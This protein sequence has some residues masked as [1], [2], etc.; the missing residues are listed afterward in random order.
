[1]SPWLF[2]GGAGPPVPS[3][4]LDILRLCDHSFRNIGISCFH[5]V[6]VVPHLLPFPWACVAHWGGL[7]VDCSEVVRLWC[8]WGAVVV[9]LTCA[10]PVAPSIDYRN[11]LSPLPVLGGYWVS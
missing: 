2:Q 11:I 10:H 5:G 1:M 3:W 8:S 4:L 7:M 6:N 9:S